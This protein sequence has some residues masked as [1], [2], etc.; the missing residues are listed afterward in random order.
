MD[1]RGSHFIALATLPLNDPAASA[2]EFERA[3]GQLGMPGAMLFSNINGVALSDEQFQAEMIKRRQ[4]TKGDVIIGCPLCNTV[5]APSSTNNQQ[6][7]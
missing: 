3:T 5:H 6:Q 1:A 7:Q 2:K 4:S